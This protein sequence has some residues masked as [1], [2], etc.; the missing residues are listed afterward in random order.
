MEK[1]NLGI[2]KPDFMKK[3]SITIK[4]SRCG[5]LCDLA[6]TS[7]SRVLFVEPCVGCEQIAEEKRYEYFKDIIEIFKPRKHKKKESK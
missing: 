2:W 6:P 5:N 3:A 4:C 1:I 7:S